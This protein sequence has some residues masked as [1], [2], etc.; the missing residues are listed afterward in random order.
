MKPNIEEEEDNSG[1]EDTKDNEDIEEGEVSGVDRDKKEEAYD[2]DQAVSIAFHL[3]AKNLLFLFMKDKEENENSEGNGEEAEETENYEDEQENY[4]NYDDEESYKD[5]DQNYDEEYAEE[6]E[7]RYCVFISFDP[8]SYPKF[9][10][11]M[12]MK[13]LTVF[14]Q[15]MRSCPSF[16]RNI[17]WT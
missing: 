12:M 7:D 6:N 2:T 11:T 15:I 1:L 4:R 16:T 17:L 5:E 8:S 13:M 10:V 9:L 3:K 14:M